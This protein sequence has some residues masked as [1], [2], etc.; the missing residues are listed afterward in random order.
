[1]SVC[2][3]GCVS[4][5]LCGC[6]CG[7]VCLCEC[8]AVCVCHCVTACE[9]MYE[10]VTVQ[11]V[12]VSVHGPASSQKGDTTTGSGFLRSLVPSG[13]A[14]LTNTARGGPAWQAGALALRWAQGP[15]TFVQRG[16]FPYFMAQ[17][18]NTPG[19]RGL[20]ETLRPTR[21]VHRGRCSLDR[22]LCSEKGAAGRP[23]WT[24]SPPCSLGGHPQAVA[25]HWAG[26]KVTRSP[27]SPEAVQA[28]ACRPTAA[29]C[30]CISQPPR[31]REQPA[32]FLIRGLP[33]RA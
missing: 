9:C 31:A 19:P 16:P 24:L 10:C 26:G 29:T 20:V 11:C 8:V 1:M 23:L 12:S 22:A 3:C 2:V 13:R 33:F 28:C 17:R 6:V 21:E 18:G 5:C 25:P 32:C 14:A 4:A 27:R 15:V 30:Q 7:S